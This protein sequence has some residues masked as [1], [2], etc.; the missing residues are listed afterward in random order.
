[1]DENPGRAVSARRGFSIRP[2][3]FKA[4]TRLGLRLISRDRGALREP[5]CSASNVTPLGRI[6]ANPEGLRQVYT[7]MPIVSMIA[8]DRGAL[9]LSRWPVSLLPSR[10]RGAL[11]FFHEANW[12]LHLYHEH[13]RSECPNDRRFGDPRRGERLLAARSGISAPHRAPMSLTDN[14]YVACEANSDCS[15]GG[16][17]TPVTTIGP[18]IV[19]ASASDNVATTAPSTLSARC[20]RGRCGAGGADS[21]RDDRLGGSE[22]RRAICTP[23]DRPPHPRTRR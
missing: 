1:M 9:P 7:L 11:E 6:P 15:D 5:G 18:S 2:P 21:G 8:R 16:V 20:E 23:T 4:V 12:H 17:C 10:T 19:S 3:R 13:L 14:Q 22:C